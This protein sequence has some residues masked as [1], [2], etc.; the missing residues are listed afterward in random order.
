VALV[1]P[2]VALLL[3]MGSVKAFTQARRP[4]FRTPFWY[5]FDVCSYMRDVGMAFDIRLFLQSL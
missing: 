4:E 2:A 3:V 1:V 5:W